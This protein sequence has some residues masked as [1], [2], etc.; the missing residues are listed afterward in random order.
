MPP[1]WFPAAFVRFAATA[2][3]AAAAALETEVSLRSRIRDLEEERKRLEDGKPC[4]LCGATDHPFAR[5]NVPELDKAETA[6]MEK[7]AEL[8]SASELVS[9]LESKRVKVSERIRHTE[10]EIAEK[11]ATRDK[12]EKEYHGVLLKRKNMVY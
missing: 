9:K 4:P 3:P 2:G 5:G 1:P 6:M 10:K 7:K 11:R 8:K 12:D